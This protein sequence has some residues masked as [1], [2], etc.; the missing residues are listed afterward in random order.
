MAVTTMPVKM[1]L[2]LLEV[3]L[4]MKIRI[5]FPAIFCKPPLI[6]DMP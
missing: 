5:R 6:R 4:A 2:K 3:I 1:H